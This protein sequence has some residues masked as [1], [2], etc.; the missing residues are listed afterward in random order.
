MNTYCALLLKSSEKPVYSVS[1][2]AISYFSCRKRC[3]S[4]KG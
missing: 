2:A 1:Q 3:P 4:T